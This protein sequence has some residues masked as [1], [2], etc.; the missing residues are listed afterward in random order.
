M[1]QQQQQTNVIHLI[2]ELKNLNKM[3]GGDENLNV[4]H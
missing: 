1:Q 4:M 2:K 3:V